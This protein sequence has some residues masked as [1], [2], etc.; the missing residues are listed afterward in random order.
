MLA[1]LILRNKTKAADELIEQFPGHSMR[2]GNVTS[3]AA[4]DVRAA[5]CSMPGTSPRP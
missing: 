3:G 4:M 1:L 5:A 2:A